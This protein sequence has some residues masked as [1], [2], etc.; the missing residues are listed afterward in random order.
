M[1]RADMIP[2]E[3]K[4]A[5]RVVW[6]R[7]N[8]GDAPEKLMADLAVAALNAWPGMECRPTLGPS[9]VILPLTSAQNS[10]PE[11]A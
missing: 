11:E 1:I 2:D 4:R 10:E 3:V 8:N 7:R 6:A 9:R 5:M